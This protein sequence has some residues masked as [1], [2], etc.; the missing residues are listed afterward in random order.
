MG[1]RR[2]DWECQA[3]G[4]E[5]DSLVMVPAELNKKTGKYETPTPPKTMRIECPG[6]DAET[7]HC[8]LLSAPAVY[9]YDKPYAPI[10][11]G[12]TYDT[13]GNRKPPPPLEFPKDASFDQVRD[14]IRTKE[15]QDRKKERWN[16]I[17][18]NNAKKARA[19]AM[20]KHPTMDIRNTPLPGD[21]PL[22]D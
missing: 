7:E 19:K 20:K 22:K 14:T 8:R 2:Y 12:G 13:T 6:C 10:V 1:F 3:C 18:Q 16:V 21:P 4:L 9:T 5:H 17:Q 11:H 15:W